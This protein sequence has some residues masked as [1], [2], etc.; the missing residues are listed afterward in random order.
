[1]KLTRFV[2]GTLLNANVLNDFE[3]P[4]KC[5]K[6]KETEIVKRF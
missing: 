1:M 6:V 3:F 2:F 4:I 5:K